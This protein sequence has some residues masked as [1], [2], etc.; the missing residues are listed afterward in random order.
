[1]KTIEQITRQITSLQETQKIQEQELSNKLE[2][3]LV[4]ISPVNIIS[5][6]I[7]SFISK[8]QIDEELPK[9]TLRFLISNLSDRFLNKSPI[10]NKAIQSILSDYLIDTIFEKKSRPPLKLESGQTTEEMER[11]I[12]YS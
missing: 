9:V 10:L 11:L 7:N 12:Q 2:N 6:S 5:N 4:N 1:M 3:L 8:N